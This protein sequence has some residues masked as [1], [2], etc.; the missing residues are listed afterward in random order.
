[1][2]KTKIV[3]ACFSKL[4]MQDWSELRSEYPEAFEFMYR[5]A[6]ERDIILIQKNIFPYSKEQERLQKYAEMGFDVSKRR[7]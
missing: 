2:D 4:K 1:M 3:N 5:R 6:I 7:Y